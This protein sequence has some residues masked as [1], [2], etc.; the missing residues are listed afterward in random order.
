MD[1]LPAV[2]ASVIDNRMSTLPKKMGT[3][4]K[5]YIMYLHMLEEIQGK[6]EHT[7][8]EHVHTATQNVYLSRKRYDVGIVKLVKRCL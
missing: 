2:L 3:H 6:I 8:N 4:P 5:T 1:Y 7:V